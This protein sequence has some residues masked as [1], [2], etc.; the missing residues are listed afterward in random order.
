MIKLAIHK[1]QNSFS[2][3]WISYCDSNK[4]SYK[5]VNCYDSNIMSDLND[6][7]ALLWHWAHHEPEGQLVARQIISAIEKMGIVVFPNI[8]TCW[9]YDDKIAQKY[10]LESINAP[11]VPSHVFLIKDE[12]IQ[13]IEKAQYPLV[14]K[15]RCGAGSQNVQ[16]VKNKYEA[17]KLCRKA[18]SKGFLAAKGYFA[19]AKTKVR[20]IPNI[21][22]FIGKM[23]RFPRSVKNIISNRRL[24]SV[25]KGYLYFQ[26]FIANNQY[27]TRITVIGDRAFGFL[28][29]VRP[30]D[31]RA[32]GSGQI[33]YDND[34]IDMR[35]VE[36]AFDVSKK[37]NTQS[38][39][40]DFIFDSENEPK[41]C[42]I[43]Y[44]YQS[45]AV[46]DCPGNWD[47]KLNW[48]KGH[49]WPEDA[50]LL[51]VLRLISES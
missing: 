30:G 21:E 49:M 38:L 34:K 36:I 47:H 6:V 17:K 33:L 28:R 15:L 44:C 23:K 3:R 41:I 40:F 13:F 29:K 51:E 9:H 46:H 14:F 25:Q 1:K 20:N 8:N 45:K 7:N 4:I 10:L 24:L 22:A 11:I 35:C 48:N 26:D 32:S 2:D 37:L 19:D 43:S 18:F 16:L 31:F 12:A 39:S 50:I 42:E 27:D 5:I